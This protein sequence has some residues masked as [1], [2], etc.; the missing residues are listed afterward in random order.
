MKALLEN[1]RYLVLIAV[2]MSLI[3]SV[4]A[5]IWGVLRGIGLISSLITTAGKDPL[6][7][8]TFIELMDSFLVATA[9]YI[10]AVA[11]YKLFIEDLNLPAWLVIHN[12][13]ELKGMLVN[14]VILV[15]GITFLEHLSE[16]EHAEETLLFGL[17]VSA[18]SGV[19]IWFKRSH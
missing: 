9:L 14:V 5:F 15:M 4:A 13:E 10:F 6:L 7:A 16:W 1:S 2:I 17:G 3:A 12:L 8:G 18:V 11:L 19:L